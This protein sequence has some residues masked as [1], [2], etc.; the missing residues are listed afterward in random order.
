MKPFPNRTSTFQRIRL[1]LARELISSFE[2]SNA[3]EEY[4]LRE[5]T[6]LWSFAL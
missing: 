2:I 4:S 3:V 6:R 5:A 1:S